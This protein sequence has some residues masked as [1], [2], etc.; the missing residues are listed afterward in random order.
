VEESLQP[1]DLPKRLGIDIQQEAN[2]FT[3]TQAHGAHSL[4]KIHASKVVQLKKGNALL[5]DV[6]IELYGEDGSRVDRIE[7]SEF[8]YDQKSGTAKAAGPVEITLM[9]P[10]VAPAIAPKATP[11][12][13]VTDKPRH[14][15]G[16]RLPPRLP[17][18]AR[19]T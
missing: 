5:H 9:R 10:G 3:Y 17:R 7:G 4:F 19:F 16:L 2:G 1:R 18:A 6:K 14:P 12:Q 11:A 13:A 8:E 15:A